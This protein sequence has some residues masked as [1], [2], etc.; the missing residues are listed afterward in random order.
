MVKRQ[1]YKHGNC[2]SGV[3]PAVRKSMYGRDSIV[4]CGMYSGDDIDDDNSND[5]PEGKRP[6]GGP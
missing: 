4:A 5:N 3:C 1:V 6:L 2:S